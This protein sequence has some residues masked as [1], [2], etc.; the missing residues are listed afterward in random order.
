M[1]NTSTERPRQRDVAESTGAADE[2][3][4][5]SR[6]NDLAYGAFYGG[7]LGGTV[8]AIFFLIVDAIQGQ[9]LY[10]PSMLGTTLFLDTI[11][12]GVRLDMV[13]LFS[14]VHFAT[15]F[16]LGG[17]ASWLHLTWAPL[18][19]RVLPLGLFVFVLLTA[20]LFVGDWLFLDGLATALGVLEILLAN[21][22]TAAAMAAFITKALPG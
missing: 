12:P 9:A 21:A 14:V 1:S 7:A 19:G 15:F 4:R 11:V 8:I 2:L 5:P 22:I 13:A 17:V 20:A 16:A 10:T 18:R 3:H 6:A